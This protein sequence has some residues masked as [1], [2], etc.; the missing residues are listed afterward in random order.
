MPMIAHSTFCVHKLRDPGATTLLGPALAF[1]RDKLSSKPAE[2]VL[3]RVEVG[4][5]HDLV[6]LKVRETRN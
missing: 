1:D 3:M 5:D 4:G 2:L 6:P